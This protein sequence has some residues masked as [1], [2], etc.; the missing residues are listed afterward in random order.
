MHMEVQRWGGGGGG[1]RFVIYTHS[2][3]LAFSFVSAADYGEDVLEVEI[4]IEGGA[5]SETVRIAEA[6]SWPNKQIV[7]RKSRGGRRTAWLEAWA[8]PEGRAIIL[9]DDIELSPAW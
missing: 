2:F 7:R 1:E 4:R 6:F 3:L 5:D 8:V 9:E